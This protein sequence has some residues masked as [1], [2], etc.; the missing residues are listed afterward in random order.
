MFP[1]MVPAPD[2]SEADD[3]ELL[4]EAGLPVDGEEVDMHMEI[5]NNS[6]LPQVDN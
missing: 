2:P 4:S 1:P 3:I 5:D 6:M